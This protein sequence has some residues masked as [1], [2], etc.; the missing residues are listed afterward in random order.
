M[1]RDAADPGGDLAGLAV[2]V[3]RRPDRAGRGRRRRRFGPMR[4]HRAAR[5]ADDRRPVAVQ[6]LVQQ[7]DEVR[8][9]LRLADRQVRKRPQ[10]RQVVEPLVRDAVRPDDAGAVDAEDDRQP[11]DA[12]VVH[13]V[14]DGP[15]QERRVNRDDGTAPA[16]RKARRERHHVA[17]RD[18]HVEKAVGESPRKAGEAR[19]VRH[20]GRQRDDPPV[21]GRGGLQGGPERRAPVARLCRRQRAGRP[22]ERADPVP[23]RGILLGGGEALALPGDDVND[24]AA[25]VF[26][27]DGQGGPQRGEVVPVDRPDVPEAE[28][29]EIAVAEEER[30]RPALQRMVDA[31]QERELQRV[32]RLL[33]R[34]LHAVVADA[35]DEPAEEAGKAARRL[36]DAHLVVVED[37]DDL[38]RRRRAVVEGLEAGAVDDRRVADH[39]HHVLARPAPVAGRR[40]AFGDGERHARMARDGGVARRLGRIRETGESAEAAERAERRVATGQDL[41]GIGLMAD[42]PDDAVRLRVEDLRERHRQLD[43]PK[44]RREMPAVRGHGPENRL[45]DFRRRHSPTFLFMISSVVAFC[46]KAGTVSTVR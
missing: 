18:A 27:R 41:P 13:H 5:I 20:A 10:H 35:R 8:L 31:A 15:L 4:G 42:V 28:L 3:A 39:R 40:I 2:P 23:G 17:L 36:G 1:H 46:P 7:R 24:D 38:A 16:G 14:V 45:P 33:R 22:V 12:H 30:L 44:R 11:C 21:A 9:V 34:R 19:P 6:G 37:E 43:R 29:L 26:L 25:L 32:P